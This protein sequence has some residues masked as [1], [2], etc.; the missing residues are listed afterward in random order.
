MIDVH[1]W[2]KRIRNDFIFPDNWAVCPYCGYKL[3]TYLKDLPKRE[4]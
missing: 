1:Y 3:F 2:I 4:D